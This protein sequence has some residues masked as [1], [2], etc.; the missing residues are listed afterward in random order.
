MNTIKIKKS[1]FKQLYDI[2]C[3]GWKTKFDEKF[4]SF[5][6]SD[7]I[8]FDRD[9]LEAMRQ[10]CTSDQTPV[11]N[12][13][14]K[15]FLKEENDLFKTTKYADVC[16]ALKVKVLTIKDFSF[17]PEWQRKKAFYSHQ[18]QNLVKYFNGDW[19]PDWNNTNQYKHFPYFEKR[20]CGWV[21]G[22]SGYRCCDSGA[23]AAVGFY[24]DEKTSSFVGKTFIDIYTGY[25]EN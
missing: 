4:K 18:I 3:E 21:F 23:G 14:F 15:N 20:S 17:L 25:L 5:N 24:K 7:T 1:S 16:K 11:F 9:F 22:V 19:T 8:E 10:A 6:F 2:A 13:I 12:K